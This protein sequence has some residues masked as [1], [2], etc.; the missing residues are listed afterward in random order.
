MQCVQ[1]VMI[2]NFPLLRVSKVIQLGSANLTTLEMTQRAAA[3]GYPVTYCPI[4]APLYT[5]SSCLGCTLNQYYNLQGLNCY[6]PQLVSNITALAIAN[7]YIEINNYTLINMEA[8]IAASRLPVQQCPP[9]HALFNGS[10]CIGCF[11]PE[12]YDLQNLT[13]YKAQLA[14]N[15]TALN[16]SNR[17]VNIGSYTL[18]NMALNISSSLVPS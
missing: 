6:S 18:A 13:C 3:H 10:M 4:T 17:Y 16:A 2:S 7:N 5:G 9:H 8:A 15:I 14:S 11:S 1:A 12:Y